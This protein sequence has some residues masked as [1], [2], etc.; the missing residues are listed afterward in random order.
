MKLK[1][2]REDINEIYKLIKKLNSENVKLYKE[3]EENEKNLKNEIKILREEL[4]KVKNENKKIKDLIDSNYNNLNSSFQEFKS[5]FENMKKLGIP[6]QRNN[7]KNNCG[8]STV[9]F[10][11]T[12][13]SYEKSDKNWAHYII[14][15]HGNGN[16]YFQVVIRLPFWGGYIQ[17]GHRENGV[18][19]GWK[20]IG[21]Y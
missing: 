21:K 20:N 17:I 9:Q 10:F 15:N 14:F 6:N 5:I 3:K 19:K 2:E 7:P 11:Q 1:S 16:S 13:E 18:W 4:E 12:N 8:T